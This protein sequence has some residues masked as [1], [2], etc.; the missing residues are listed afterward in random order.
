MDVHVI[1][2]EDR[3]YSSPGKEHEGSIKGLLGGRSSPEKSFL[4]KLRS[5][6]M[7]V[8]SGF[9]SFH[10]PTTLRINHTFL[11]CHP[12]QSFH[13]GAHKELLQFLE[14]TPGI[15]TIIFKPYSP[16][17]EQMQERKNT[18]IKLNLA[19]PTDLDRFVVIQWILEIDRKS[20]V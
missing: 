8:K 9:D 5:I 15:T 14:I 13:Q 10:N 4:H 18:K 1:C 12:H 19:V 17:Q 16:L 3:L 6:D 11:D 7:A 20:V 2:I